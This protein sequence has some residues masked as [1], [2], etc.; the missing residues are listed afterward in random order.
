VAATQS[1]PSATGGTV[2]VPGGAAQVTLAANGFVNKATG[3]AVSGPVT[4]QITPINPA[5]DPA[6]MPGNYSARGSDG[7]AQT[8]ESFGALNVELADGAGNRLDLA[9]GQ[10]ATV[11][12]P[13]ASRSSTPPSTI[14]LYYFDESA[15][16][17]AQQGTAAL[18]GVAP[19]QYYEGTVAHFSFWN[20][21]RPAETI[22]VHGCVKDA[23][24]SLSVGATVNTDGIDYSG[25]SA[26]FTDANGNFTVPIRKGGTA[27]LWADTATGTSN[28]VIVGPSDVDIYLPACLVLGPP[29]PPVIVEQPLPVST[30]EGGFAQFK[31]VAHGS[32]PL[33][34]QW[35]RNGVPIAAISNFLDLYTVG[36]ADNGAQFTVVV[37]NDYGSVTSDTV[38]LT[39]GVQPPGILSAPL[40]SDVTAGTTATFAVTTLQ[41]TSLLSFQWQRNGTPITG[42]NGPSYTT[43]TTTLANNGDLYSVTLTNSAGVV[44]S[45]QAL[46]TV[47]VAAAP[48]I[49]QNP[50]N[51]SVT[52]GQSAV[53]QVAAGG[54]PPLSFQWRKNGTAINGATASSYTTPSTVLADNGAQFTVVISNAV[55]SL[56]SN[57]A[58]LS[59][60]DPTFVPSI[61]QQPQNITTTSGQTAT[62]SVT[63]SGTAPL[64]YQWLRNGTEVTGATAPSYTTPLLALSDNN[65][66]FTVQV[67][68]AQGSVLSNAAMLTVVAAPVAPVISS[69]PQSTA[70]LTGLTATF[71]VT[72]TGT[73]P[74]TYQWKRNGI[75]IASAAAASYTTPVLGVTDSGAVFTVL[76]TNAVGSV[77]SSGAT[78]TVTASQAGAGR[79]L[80]AQAGPSS[81]AAFVYANGSQSVDST[82]ILAAP[83]AAATGTTVVEA[84]GQ[85]TTLF[86]QVVAGTVSGG[87]V[88]DLHTRYA[89]YFKSGRLYQIDHQVATGTPHGVPLS[90]LAPSDVCAIGTQGEPDLSNQAGY[91][92]AD[93]T[94][95]WVFFAAPV[96]GVCSSPSDSYRAVRM[97][98]GDADVALTVGEPVAAVY[99][100]NAA[101]TGYILRNG[102]TF[103]KVDANLA[104]PTTLFTLAPSAFKSF[105]VSFGASA[106]GVWLFVN[107]GQLYA[108]SLATQA[109]TPTV[110]AT[111]QAG[112]QVGS[113]LSDGA[114]GYVSITGGGFVSPAFRII[115]VATTL[116]STM[117][118]SGTGQLTNLALTPSRIVMSTSSF[119][120]TVT[121]NV[122]SVL[123][124]GT[125]LIDIGGANSGFLTIFAYTSGENVYLYEYGIDGTGQLS[126]VR[127]RILGSDGSNV[128][129]LANT[130]IAGV[131]QGANVP[132]V[133]TIAYSPYA[134]LFIDNVGPDGSAS[135]GT[136]RSVEG[137]TRAA[138]LSYGTVQATPPAA[139]FPGPIDPYQYGLSGL[140]T[141]TPTSASAGS[142][143]LY[144]VDTA[145]AGSLTKVTGFVAA[146]GMAS[147]AT[148]RAPGRRQATGLTLPI[149][150]RQLAN[151]RAA[152]FR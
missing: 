80:V 137:S 6:N 114:N 113:V 1:V 50:A 107:G 21:D 84:A 31:V 83:A 19:N 98:M 4:V 73:S 103:Q 89:L 88:S 118:Y 99:D 20:A 65:A 133:R 129:T 61:S 136:L 126:G 33:R 125:G 147:P 52:T 57:P 106:P 7:S 63:A 78:L 67:S 34:Y 59:V 10:T 17:W 91:D 25:A 92:L 130:G 90:T 102:S 122:S 49:T 70:V 41:P 46:L 97:S 139:F 101:I 42:A 141:F 132:L 151:Q 18:G 85:A 64:S 26:G 108:Y 77:I 30:Q 53:F 112:E 9:A 3:A 105:G 5:T 13:L 38:R 44:T 56:T 2:T 121:S 127:T 28:L 54:S 37:T 116:V 16:L 51:A 123:R 152:Q 11:R 128:Q 150:R 15:G 48:T 35:Q 93:A 68:N 87:L 66:S 14:P 140:F 23:A 82:A 24:G 143:D 146:S 69:Q 149:I 119:G 75:D 110:V 134:V 8:I 120:A 109:S 115:R 145:A 135:G 58:T 60:A 111:L 79:Y 124:D 86:G 39:V 144:F 71:S 142:S 29:G 22:Y 104:N 94:R 81:L 32:Q 36:G 62:F 27:N 12:I 74:L 43:P 100:G 72:A 55:G 148:V 47:Q 96:S 40:D 138:L 45:R 95:N 131:L 117:L 76:V